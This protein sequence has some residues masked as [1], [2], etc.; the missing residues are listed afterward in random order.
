MDAAEISD[1]RSYYRKILRF[2]TLESVSRAHLDFWRRT[3]RR[4]KPQRI[5][6]IGSGLGRITAALSEIAPAVGVDI[7]MEMVARAPRKARACLVLAD[8]RCVT[9]RP[10][11]DLIVAPGDP[12]SHLTTLADRRRALRAV[13]GQLAPGGTFVLEGLYRR[14]HAV[15]HPHRTIRHAGGVLQ[16][17]EGWFPVGIG[18]LWHARYNYIDRRRD[19]SQE[20][21]SAAFVARAWN[22]RTI[23]AEFATAGLRIES[24]RGD[25]DGRPFTPASPRIVVFA[26][27]QP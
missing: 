9:F 14:R 16:I 10:A 12:L 22:R 11:F 4:L 21:L 7:S 23:E 5:L 2:Y 6:E 26:G 15:T 24:V 18:D 13:R 25:F 17:D 27:K 1:A 3:A 20:S 8:A 19:G